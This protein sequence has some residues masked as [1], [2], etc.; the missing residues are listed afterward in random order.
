MP[1]RMATLS[2]RCSRTDTIALRTLPAFAATLAD[3]ITGEGG[4][5]GA[6]EKPSS[7][8]SHAI[9]TTTNDAETAGRRR[10][11]GIIGTPR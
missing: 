7:V 2:A 8:R 6:G 3:R 11:T 4:S 5:G 10:E 1:Y 9:T